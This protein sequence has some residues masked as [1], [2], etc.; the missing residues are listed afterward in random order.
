MLVRVSHLSC[1]L[2]FAGLLVAGANAQ[3]YSAFSSNA[4]TI[5][6]LSYSLQSLSGTGGNVTATFVVTLSA[7]AQVT[8]GNASGDLIGKVGGFFALSSNGALSGFTAG[9]PSQTGWSYSETNNHQVAGWNSASSGNGYASG[10]PFLA[11]PTTGSVTGT[12]TFNHF[13]V[14]DVTSF[15]FDYQIKDSSTT[16]HIEVLKSQATPEPSSMAAIAGVLGFG[17]IRR[18][19]KA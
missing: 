8:S 3:S 7:G 12:F 9:T 5:S 15:G 13:I 11:V 2:S 18:R 4:G 19:R 6:G 17:L 14:A 16:K 1:V 10:K